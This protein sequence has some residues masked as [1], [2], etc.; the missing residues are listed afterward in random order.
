MWSL[1]IK[2]IASSWLAGRLKERTSW[3]GFV[4]IAIG[5]AIVIFVIVGNIVFGNNDRAPGNAG[6]PNGIVINRI[7]IDIG[8]VVFVGEIDINTVIVRALEI[9]ND[10]IPNIP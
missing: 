10:I 4:L 6:N 1:I 7:V 5:T 3:N 8:P 9:I 2:S